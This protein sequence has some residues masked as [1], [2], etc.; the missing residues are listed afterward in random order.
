MRGAFLVACASIMVPAATAKALT[1]AE[2]DAIWRQGD[3]ARMK[4]IAERGDVRAFQ[5]MGLML[6]ARRD[7]GG[8]RQWYQRAAEK[9]D[10]YAANTLG[11]YYRHGT[12]VPKSQDRARSWY[13]RGAEIGY[14]ASQFNCAWALREQTPRNPAGAFRW[15]LTAT[16]QGNRDSYLPLAEMYAEGEGTKRDPIR[17]YAFALA[18]EYGVEDSN[19]RDQST[20]RQLKERLLIELSPED[21]HRAEAML[22]RYRPNLAAKALGRDGSVA[23]PLWLMAGII[24]LALLLSGSTIR[25]ERKS[26]DG[27]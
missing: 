21:R 26:S 22:T 19:V 5:R 18:A 3:L 10:G 27:S 23:V 16:G 14:A 6:Q 13:C 12:G 17:A 15:F 24:G 4:S 2:L 8:A 9:G 20:A 11:Y 7:F 1:D 25:P